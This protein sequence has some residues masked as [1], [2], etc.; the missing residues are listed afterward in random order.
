MI[1]NIDDPQW[2][3]LA[4]LTDFKQ[5]NEVLEPVECAVE[6]SIPGWLHG[7]LYRTG[8][9]IFDIQ[10][11]G[12]TISLDHW[13]DGIAITHLFEIHQ[14]G[15]VTYRNR[16]TGKSRKESIE[17]NGIMAST[18]GPFKD[19][20]QA[21]YKKMFSVFGHPSQPSTLN[22]TVSPRLML[23]GEKKPLCV[24]KTDANALQFIDPNTLIPVEGPPKDYGVLN[25]ELAKYPFSAAHEEYDPITDSF[26]NIVGNMGNK[27]EYIVFESFQNVP[28]TTATIL[29]KF[30]DPYANFIH[31]FSSTSKYVIIQFWPLSFGSKG[32]K[33]F[34]TTN[35][36]DALEWDPKR[37]ARFI[38]IDRLEQRVVVEYQHPADFCFHTVNAFDDE[39]TGDVVLDLLM[40][41]TGEQLAAYSV[42]QLRNITD[43][44][45]L[46]RI[47][48]LTTTRFQRL[49][50][51]DLEEAR[52][53][54]VHGDALPK[55]A[56]FAQVV[57]DDSISMELPRINPKWRHRADY[58]FVYGVSTMFRH[59]HSHALF[60]SL[61]KFDV[62]T[63]SHVSWMKV[64]HTPSEPMF[65]PNPDGDGSEDDGVVLSIVLDGSLNKSYMLVLD[66]KNFEE[67]AKADIGQALPY[68]LHGAFV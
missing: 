25:S 44:E 5:E 8:P 35:M 47:R 53:T 6:G 48:T 57:F 67:L 30:K 20:C 7:Q 12:R 54:Y 56:P 50:L 1:G 64:G 32:K 16:V 65:V 55:T 39:D 18:I 62:S 58:R 60:D 59:L 41:G 51:A 9:G 2:P 46:K 19:P 4:A 31:S 36:V 43:Q 21:L 14:G 66:A 68:G 22:V 33:L 27:A 11:E 28:T 23:P 34:E 61:V 15:K 40:S 49:R 37:N 10:A 38:V 3:F 24:L 63:Q 45:S 17:R 42:S 26:M 29:A 52:M 13:F